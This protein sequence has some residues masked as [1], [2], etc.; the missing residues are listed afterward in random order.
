M[1]R[2]QLGLVLLTSAFVALLPLMGVA[3]M[4]SGSWSPTRTHWIHLALVFPMIGAMKL[5]FDRDM[6]LILCFFT[7]WAIVFTLLFRYTLKK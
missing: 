2:A 7:Y 4:T 3:W 5:G 1:N 6:G